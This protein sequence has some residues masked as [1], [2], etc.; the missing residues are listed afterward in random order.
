MKIIVAFKFEY[1]SSYTKFDKLKCNLVKWWTS[2]DYYHVELIYK[3]KW[4][5][6]HTKEGVIERD[7]VG[8]EEGYHYI[9]LE[10]KNYV[11][12]ILD[13]YIEGELGCEYD[14]LGIYLSQFI[15]LGVS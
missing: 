13:R 7:F 10:I 3:N 1:D 4:I 15:K 6:A 12:K 8:Y 14:W 5:S 9:E 2:S 11:C